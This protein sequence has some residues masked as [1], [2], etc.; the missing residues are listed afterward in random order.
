M[1]TLPLGLSLL[2]GEYYGTPDP[3]SAWPPACS[4]RSPSWSSSS[5]QRY[6]VEGLTMTGLKG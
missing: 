3:A 5:S 2:N 1:H 6:L 4:A